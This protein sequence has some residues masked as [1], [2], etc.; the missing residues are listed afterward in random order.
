MTQKS[1]KN[2]NDKDLQKTELQLNNLVNE[3]KKKGFVTYDE[4]NKSIAD[5]KKLSVEELEN[6]ISKFSDAGIDIIEDD[7]EDI[8]LDINVNQELTVSSNGRAANEDNNNENS[9]SENHSSTDDPVRLY[10]RDM[11]GVEL[12]SRENEVELAKKIDNGKALMLS[13]LCESPTAIRR[14]IKWYEDLVNEK[15]SLRELIDLDSNL[16]HEAD[17]INQEEDVLNSDESSSKISGEELSEDTQ[18]E[19]SELASSSLSISAMESE[20]LPSM[21]DK[22]EIISQN[23][24]II[25]N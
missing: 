21:L 13:S 19:E 1:D 14:F 25:L 6:A 18:E 16:G 10:L 4:L 17:L 15:I 22:M 9:S 12:L 8:K 23:C 2:V 5:S 24:E 20:L 7:N 11:G 3:S